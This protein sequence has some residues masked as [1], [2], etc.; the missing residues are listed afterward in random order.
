MYSLLKST[1]FVA[2]IALTTNVFAEEDNNSL[3]EI[4]EQVIFTCQVNSGKIISYCASNDLNNHD[5]YVQY[6]FGLKR[7]IELTL[8]DDFSHPKNIKTLFYK[9]IKNR[10]N[11]YL[12]SLSINN[13]SYRYVAWQN[14]SSAESGIRVL[15]GKSTVKSYNCSNYRKFDTD[16]LRYIKLKK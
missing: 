1:L 15:R 16:L 2:L 4:D 8:P 9:K 3:C 12:Y 14:P 13:G 5:G 11:E 7:D 6:R 10:A